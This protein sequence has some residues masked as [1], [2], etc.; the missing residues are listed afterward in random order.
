MSFSDSFLRNLVGENK[1]SAQ[2]RFAWGLDSCGQ[3]INDLDLVTHPLSLG[4][5]LGHVLTGIVGHHGEI[6]G[7]L[8]EKGS[9]EIL[10]NATESKT[11]HQQLSSILD[12]MHC[13][14]STFIHFS[15]F[16]LCW[17]VR[18]EDLCDKQ[19]YIYSTDRTSSP[20]GLDRAFR[21]SIPS[22]LLRF[23]GKFQINLHERQ[24]CCA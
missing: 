21:R 8:L 4:L 9:Y 12:I 6:G 3:A 1:K 15:R 23:H 18:K 5:S 20:R 24:E 10:R 19:V 11:T 2:G 7:F 16:F 17:I 14:K 13:I 22:F